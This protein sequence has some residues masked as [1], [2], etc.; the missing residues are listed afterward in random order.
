MIRQADTAAV[1]RELQVKRQRQSPAG[2]VVKGVV[3]EA[4]TGAEDTLDETKLWLLSGD[5]I[6][7]AGFVALTVGLNGFLN[8]VGFNVMLLKNI[9]QPLQTVSIA[10][11]ANQVAVK[12]GIVTHFHPA[13]IGVF[14]KLNKTCFVLVGAINGAQ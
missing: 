5:K 13:V 11:I 4:L 2:H 14:L 12:V 10:A 8:P 6:A 9:Q 7:A 1:L 3:R